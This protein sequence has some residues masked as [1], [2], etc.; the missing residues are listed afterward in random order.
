MRKR[1]LRSRILLVD[2]NIFTQCL[3]TVCGRSLYLNTGKRG[4]KE[5]KEGKVGIYLETTERDLETSMSACLIFN[6]DG[7]SK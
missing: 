7:P 1:A 5:D 6:E 3:F 4:R 2:S